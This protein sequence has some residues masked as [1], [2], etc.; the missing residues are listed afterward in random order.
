MTPRPPIATGLEPQV[1]VADWRARAACRDF[2]TEL[3]FPERGSDRRSD[4]HRASIAR[5]VCALCPVRLPCLMVALGYQPRG[6]SQM[7]RSSQLAGIW[8][9][10]NERERRALRRQ[11]AA[12][13]PLAE[14]VAEAP[15][16][17]PERHPSR[18]SA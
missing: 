18:M 2:P 4:D 9:G 3:F 17:S 16:P 13:R 11:I 7:P 10:T 1:Y 12:G 5:S 14:V 15:V 6:E 8:G